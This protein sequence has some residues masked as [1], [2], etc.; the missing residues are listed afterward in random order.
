MYMTLLYV[1]YLYGVI[2]KFFKNTLFDRTIL[3]ETMY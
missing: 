3:I 1:T 2:Y